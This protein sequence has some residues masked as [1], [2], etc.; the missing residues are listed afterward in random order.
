MRMGRL[1]GLLLAGILIG[2][3]APAF[4]ADGPADGRF[5]ALYEQE[6]SWRQK[7][8]ARTEEEAGQDGD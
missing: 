2:A 7:E 3:G 8:M 1:A 5:K 6:W 4:A